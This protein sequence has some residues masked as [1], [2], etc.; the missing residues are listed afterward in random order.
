MENTPLPKLRLCSIALISMLVW[1][2]STQLAQATSIRAE[3]EPTHIALGEE[4]VLSVVV[5]GSGNDP[6][7]P[8]L[9]DFSVS[10]RG[11][12][13]QMQF[14]NGTFS[15]SKIHTFVLTPN[16]AGTLSIGPITLRASGKTVQSKPLQLR[17]QATRRPG[18]ANNDPLAE[19][20][21]L[22]V[23]ASLDRSEAFVGEQ[24][25]YTLRLFHR[26]H[27]RLGG[28]QADIPP[29]DDFY[30][31][32]LGQ[33]KNQTV[34][35]D[36]VAYQM[37]QVRKALFAQS[38]G[39]YIL[40]EAKIIAEVLVQQRR[41]RGMGGFSDLFSMGGQSQ[42][43][44]L[45]SE[46]IEIRIQALPKPPKGFSGLVGDFELSATLL[47]TTL[48]PGE[49]STWTLRVAG[50]GN[51]H[52]IVSPIV[53]KIERIKIYDDR[54]TAELGTRN[55]FLLGQKSFK[56]AL[57][58][59]DAQAPKEIRSIPKATL[60]VFDPTTETYITHT[61][62][63]A[64]LEVYAHKDTLKPNALSSNVQPAN[65]QGKTPIQVTQG[66]PR[67]N[68]QDLDLQPQSRLAWFVALPWAA[69]PPCLAL[70]M[71][72]W[73]R[74]QDEDQAKPQS[75]ERRQA[76][77]QLTKRVDAAKKYAK[78][79]EQNA[80]WQELEQG[81]R[82]YV[83]AKLA[84]EAQA[85]TPTEMG[86]VVAAAG[87]HPEHTAALVAFLAQ[88]ENARYSGAKTLDAR[89]DIAAIAK[90]AHAMEQVL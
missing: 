73:R 35:L 10:Q 27:V 71:I 65:S 13:S 90:L 38:S 82:A 18:R 36:G 72:A 64:Q 84:C 42:R 5:E 23:E 9:H 63:P 24:I 22:F 53:P 33:E 43:R 45:T 16:K 81:L 78:Q 55:G 75:K 58:P 4:A 60:I 79:G 48:Q 62:K 83:S 21:A 54:P 49:A 67:P 40:P 61:T 12:S 80:A 44:V 41:R 57:V 86:S 17:V 15:R 14:I 69:L 3:L 31:H 89:P 52:Q 6:E 76:K 34:R 87:L 11:T 39:T 32:D 74:K 70:L 20:V 85:F 50:T 19:P 59:I 29:F 2:S 26:P 7:L 30:V 25:Q 28:L 68:R 51:A 1:A 47:P 88:V 46:K 37:I 8:E 77:A 56:K 66:M